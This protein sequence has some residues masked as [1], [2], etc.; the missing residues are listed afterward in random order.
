MSPADLARIQ[1]S[2]RSSEGV[3]QAD[4][5]LLL[6]EINTIPDAVVEAI[7]KIIYQVAYDYAADQSDFNKGRA[8][9]SLVAACILTEPALLKVFEATRE[10]AVSNAAGDCGESAED[11]EPCGELKLPEAA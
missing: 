10:E 5:G 8:V 2:Y 7:K 9:F 3:Q 4:V 1:R 11:F 6:A